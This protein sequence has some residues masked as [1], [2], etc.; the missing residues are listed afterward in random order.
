MKQINLPA[1]G[2]RRYLELTPEYWPEVDTT[3]E[4]IIKGPGRPIV[5]NSLE[6][7]R[8]CAGFRELH[9]ADDDDLDFVKTCEERHLL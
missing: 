2:S 1:R 3:N 6:A 8:L 5:E 7:T 9:L 4:P